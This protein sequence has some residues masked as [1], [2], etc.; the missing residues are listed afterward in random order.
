MSP[1]LY[2][3]SQPVFGEGYLKF[4]NENSFEWSPCGDATDAEKII[5]FSGR[6]CYLSFDPNPRTRV[7]TR[8]YVRKLISHGHESVLE[9]A[10]WTFVL[11]GVTRGFSHQIVRHRVGFSFSQLSQQ[12]HDESEAEILEPAGLDE[13]PELLEA[14][15]EMEGKVRKFYELAAK[16]SGA[17]TFL[18]AREKSRYV[19]TF[20]RSVLPNATRTML[21]VTANARALRHFL[22]IRGSIEGDIEMRQVSQLIFDLLSIQ[23]P[24]VVADFKQV[25]LR[26]GSPSIIKCS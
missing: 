8:E 21:S 14:W 10:H 2:L 23:A 5:E 6:L 4:L 3:L 19:R 13:M 16:N 9:H 26:D 25:S 7:P 24:E 17:V 18:E 1:Q 15:R 11:D 12:Y 22:T 20:A